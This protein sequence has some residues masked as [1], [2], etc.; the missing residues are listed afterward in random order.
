MSRNKILDH[1]VEK[2]IRRRFLLPESLCQIAGECEKFAVAKAMHFEFREAVQ[3]EHALL[4][5]EMARNMCNQFVH[6][7][8]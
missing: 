7:C 3:F 5:L 1:K 2:D 4:M 8:R 6:L